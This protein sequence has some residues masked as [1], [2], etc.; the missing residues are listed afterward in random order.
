MEA[1][2]VTLNT[3]ERMAIKGCSRRD[4]IPQYTYPP[5]THVNKTTYL[6]NDDLVVG[7]F[8]NGVARAYPHRTLWNHEI[9]NDTVGGVRISVNHCPLTGTSLNFK[10]ELNGEPATFGVSGLLYNNNLILYDHQTNSYWPQMLFTAAWGPA[11][12]TQIQLLPVYEMT[13][14]AWKK[15]FPDSDVVSSRLANNGRYPYGDYYINDNKILFPQKID[16]R[17][18][19][20]ELV[21]GIIGKRK[22]KVYPFKNMKK[23]DVINDF[24]GKDAILLIFDR[25][26]EMA[27]A[28]K[29]SLINDEYMEFKR[30]DKQQ[31]FPF[32]I[33]DKNG[34]GKWNILG[35]SLTGGKDLVPIVTAFKGF[36]LSWGSYYRGIEI[37]TD[38]NL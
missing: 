12:G 4:C 19:S 38:K 16:H 2:S 34:Y 20:K 7:V 27:V 26:A 24:V 30:A 28:Y 9:A 21:F 3:I 22:A 14:A 18:G 25:S 6:S 17:L 31:K 11:K 5:L 35:L 8:I 29:R 23:R 1:A 10:G 36:W 32:D 37:Y 13:W 33:V 15:L